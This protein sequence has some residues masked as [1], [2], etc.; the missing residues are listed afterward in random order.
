MSVESASLVVLRPV[1][2]RTIMWVFQKGFNLFSMKVHLNGV[3]LA[4]QKSSSTSAEKIKQGLNFDNNTEMHLGWLL[5]MGN[6]N[7]KSPYTASKDE[8]WKPPCSAAEDKQLGADQG[9]GER[10]WGVR[11]AASN[12]SQELQKNK[13]SSEG[14]HI[15]SA[16]IK[17]QG[18]STKL[19]RKL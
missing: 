18:E 19:S 3:L 15:I 9:G 1:F 10:S 14:L 11:G 4:F 8:N 5:R 12:R 2:E 17:R 7:S 16:M 6:P 13:Y